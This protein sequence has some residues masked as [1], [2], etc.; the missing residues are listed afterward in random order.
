MMLQNALDSQLKSSRP[1]GTCAHPDP[2]HSLSKFAFLARIFSCVSLLLPISLQAQTRT[3]LPRRGQPPVAPAAPVDPASLPQGSPSTDRGNT[4]SPPPAID[5]K[6]IARLPS[7][8]GFE[9]QPG[10]AGMF[11]GS[12][13]LFLLVAGGANYTEGQALNEAPK[14]YW[15]KIFVLEKAPKEDGN[16]QYTWRPSGFDLPQA[17][18]YGASVTIDDGLLC[19]GGRGV[20]QCF[21]DCFVL[22]WNAAQS[23]VESQPFPKLPSPLAHMSAARIGNIV[24]VVGG[25][26]TSHG[27]ATKTFLALDLSQQSNPATFAWQK[28]P[29]WD[30]PARIHALA[31]AG[32]DGETESL[33]VCGGRNPGAGAE[34]FLT[35][36]HRYDPKKKAWYVLG[37]ALDPAGNT[38]T[39]M[40]APAFFVPP[41][42]LVVVGGT[43][44]KLI[45]LMEDNAHRQATQDMTESADRRKLN[46]LIME[47]FPG[48]SRNVMAFDIIASEWSVIKTN[49]PDRPPVATVVVPW[50]GSYVIPGGETGPGKRSN[51]IWEASVKKKARIIE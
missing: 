19:I 31:S 38:A 24:Y 17:I 15:D 45:E 2:M 26:E 18:A 9:T 27:R 42:H 11:A 3:A 25:R 4:L 7:V 46:Q 50:D 14:A 37:D 12:Q 40:A 22:R 5:W 1:C 47:N 34:D 39:L 49:F 51:K 20:D 16:H 36:L 33:Y 41:H 43:D 23:K 28:L 35:D 30:G 29:A 48:Y 8:P 13:G 32:T 6:E 44:Q 21:A 10:V